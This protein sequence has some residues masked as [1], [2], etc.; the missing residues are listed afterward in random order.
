LGSHRV[1]VFV[2]HDRIEYDE[3]PGTNGETLFRHVVRAG[4]TP[5]GGTEV[6]VSEETELLSWAT[7]LE[8]LNQDEG[9]QIVAVATEPDGQQVK[10]LAVKKLP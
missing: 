8:W 9:I 3:A 7:T 4:L 10:G 2:T 6:E 1:S 5:P